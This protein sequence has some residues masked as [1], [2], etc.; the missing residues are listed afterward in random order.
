MK[1]YCKHKDIL[2]ESDDYYICPLCPDK[3]ETIS[4]INS[5]ISDDTTETRINCHNILIK[6]YLRKQKLNRILE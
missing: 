1:R 3:C 5:M 2:I 6:N 4:I